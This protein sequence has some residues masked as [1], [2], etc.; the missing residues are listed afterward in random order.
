[1]SRVKYVDFGLV[2]AV[3]SQLLLVAV[4]SSYADAKVKASA[5]KDE[6]KESLRRHRDDEPEATEVLDARHRVREG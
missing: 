5:M 6:R 2:V 3:T 1:M 4:R